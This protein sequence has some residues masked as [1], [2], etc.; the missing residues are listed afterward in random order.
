MLFRENYA[1]FIIRT[2]SSS[3]TSSQQMEVSYFNIIKTK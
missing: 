2:F 1:T 3:Q